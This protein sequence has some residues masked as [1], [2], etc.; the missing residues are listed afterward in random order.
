MMRS[1]AGFQTR[2]RPCSI[3][4][5]DAVGDAVQDRHENSGLLLQALFR[6]LQC[7][8]APF[9]FAGGPFE[10]FFGPVAV[11]DVPEHD[12]RADNLLLGIA[13]RGLEHLDIAFL[14][15]GFA[16][17]FDVFEQGP[18]RQDLFVPRTVF[19][20]QLVRENVEVGRAE[21]VIRVFA[22]KLEI[23]PV[24][25]GV[26]AVSVL[27]QDRQRQMIDERM[28]QCLGIAQGQRRLE[29]HFAALFLG[30]RELLALVLG[31]VP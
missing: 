27:S 10:R 20:R 23:A 14:A 11:G 24:D 3:G 1:A 21:I 17:R 4:D 16:V 22:R 29:P 7:G 12:L 5:D 28:V 13:D 2:N 8:I 18:G 25:E 19:G 31:L 9:Q 15:V 6:F 26:F 30:L